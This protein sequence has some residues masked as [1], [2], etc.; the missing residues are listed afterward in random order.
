VKRER[1][2]PAATA[3]AERAERPKT[4]PP[5]ADSGNVVGPTTN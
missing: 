2:E 3:A 4:D 1:S 5:E